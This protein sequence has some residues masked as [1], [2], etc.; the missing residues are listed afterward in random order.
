MQNGESRNATLPILR[1]A[2]LGDE[3][4]RLSDHRIG[5]EREGIFVDR[6]QRTSDNRIAL[7]DERLD[8]VRFDAR[9]V[10]S[11]EHVAGR[12]P[13]PEAFDRDGP[14]QLPIQGFDLAF[15]PF[16][17]ERDLE[18]QSYPILR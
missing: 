14:L 5:F 4:H 15:D 17:R 18:P 11:L 16:L 6:H 10:D 9:L 8:D 12:L 2:R 13:F 1:H 7:V 3:G